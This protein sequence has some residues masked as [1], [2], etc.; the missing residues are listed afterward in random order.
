MRTMMILAVVAFA[1]PARADDAEARNLYERAAKAYNLQDFKT[2]LAMF[3]LAYVE[4]P[5]P[6]LL[7]NIAQS[8]RQLGQYEA[9]GKSYR[10]FLATQPEARL[11][12]EAE[13]FARQMDEAAKVVRAA[14]PPVGV[15]APPTPVAEVRVSPPRRPW[16][17]NGLGLGVT[18]SG[19]A[20][21]IAGSALLGVGARDLDDARHATT[22]PMQQRLQGESDTF[23]TAGWVTLGIGGAAVVAGVVIF[24]VR[25]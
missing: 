10:A 19:L 16:Y 2:A 8:Q 4:A 15:V 12:P 3:R 23:N 11:R 24:A 13:R 18:A 17:R 21:A 25:R 20:V 5:K 22:L 14:M 6:L 9:A 7:F 1:C